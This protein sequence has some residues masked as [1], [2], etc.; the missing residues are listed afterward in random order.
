MMDRSTT[1]RHDPRGPLIGDDQAVALLS[2]LVAIPSISGDEHAAAV[3]LSSWLAAHGADAHVDDSGS[4]VGI[5]SGAS[6]ASGWRDIVLLGHIDTVPGSIPV[7]IEHGE[8][9]GRGSVDA[10]GSLATFAAATAGIAIPPGIR[11]IVI[12]ATEEEAASSRGAR[13]AAQCFS[14][15]ACI[16]GEPSGSGAVTIGYKGRLVVHAS[17]T[18]EG[19][20]SAGPEA[21]A[22]EL[23]FDRWRAL[24][25]LGHS[26]APQDAAVF[27]RVQCKL[28]AINSSSDGLHDRAE[29]H[30]GLRLPPGVDPEAVEARIREL[31]RDVDARF[32]GH[33]HAHVDHPRSWLVQCLTRA[34]RSRGVQP[35]LLKKTGTSDMNVVARAWSCPIVAYG[36]G[37]SALDHSPVERLPIT[38]YLDAVRTLRAALSD[39]AA[40][41]AA[42]P[43]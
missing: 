17:I 25:E 32:T 14:P 10:K 2:E 29:M 12:G 30:I 38:E 28:R 3:Y 40:E 16:I 21:T 42:T 15:R 8:L 36:P 5:F 20:H 7:R 23:A 1:P 24:A 34:I 11:I 27:D 19:A 6:T 18:T 4:A 31:W 26:L 41:L 39:A 33:E 43:A 22:A 37:D 35:R 9:W 13:H